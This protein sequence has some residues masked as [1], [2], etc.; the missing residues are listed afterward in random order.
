[1]LPLT[2]LQLHYSSDDILSFDRAV[3]N[4]WRVERETDYATMQWS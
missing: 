4:W 1:M 2:Y 3:T